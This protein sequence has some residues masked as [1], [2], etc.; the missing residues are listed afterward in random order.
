M[1]KIEV[2]R[3]IQAVHNRTKNPCFIQIGGF[4]GKKFDPI[5]AIMKELRWPG[6]ICE[7][8]PYS[9]QQLQET[10]RER[11]EVQLAEIAICS[12]GV[13]GKVGMKTVSE[14]GRKVLPHW[15]AGSSS[16]TDRNLMGGN[17]CTSSSY[18]KMLKYQ[19]VVRVSALSW[20]DFRSRYCISSLPLL[21][22]DAE[23][24]DYEILKQV[25]FDALN[26]QIVHYEHYFLA[27]WEQV[28]LLYIFGILGFVCEQIGMNTLATRR[29]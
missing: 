8:I 17:R 4:D 14:E 21:Q 7:P 23:G 6:I 20:N 13:S 16:M 12:A 22:V 5:Y 11:P 18:A 19:E 27:P 26:V 3:A 28:E 9:F 2:E 25:D 29:T 15:M 1:S 10:Y 24:Y